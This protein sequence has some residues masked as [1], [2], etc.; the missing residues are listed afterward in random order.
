MI[1]A[2]R[3]V[4]AYPDSSFSVYP[5][6]ATFGTGFHMYPTKSLYYKY[7][8]KTRCLKEIAKLLADKPGDDYDD[9]EKMDFLDVD[10]QKA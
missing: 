9:F 2:K 7:P 10:K 5:V 8:P 3:Q 1:M 4:F 6:L